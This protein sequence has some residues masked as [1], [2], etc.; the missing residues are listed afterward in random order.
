MN[1]KET[2]YHGLLDHGISL[3]CILVDLKGDTSMVSIYPDLF[4][5]CWTKREYP[6][7]HTLK[8]LRGNNT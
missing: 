3:P 6:L 4:K 8:G 7:E 5:G 2:V 1:F